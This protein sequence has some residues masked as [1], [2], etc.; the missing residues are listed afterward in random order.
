MFTNCL[1]YAT[2]VS[3]PYVAMCLC[4]VCIRVLVQVPH[5]LVLDV[6]QEIYAIHHITIFRLLYDVKSF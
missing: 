6:P 4:L 2:Y 1:L 3:V 5:Y